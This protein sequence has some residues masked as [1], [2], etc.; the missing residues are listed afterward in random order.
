ML[1]GCPFLYKLVEGMDYSSVSA[2]VV[3]ILLQQFIGKG[4]AYG[5]DLQD[6]H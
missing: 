4:E 3:L 5:T 1:D 2:W 6:R